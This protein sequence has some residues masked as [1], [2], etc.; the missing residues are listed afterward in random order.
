MLALLGQGTP[1]STGEL[2]ALLGLDVTAVR[3]CGSRLADAKRVV[4]VG[5]RDERPWAGGWQAGRQMRYGA[6]LLPERAWRR[7]RL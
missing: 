5:Y 6:W 3:E 4:R 7:Q 2:A 1:R